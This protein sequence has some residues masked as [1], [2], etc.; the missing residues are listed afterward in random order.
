[1]KRAVS[2][3]VLILTLTVFAVTK[4]PTIG[5]YFYM[6]ADNNLA[7]SANDEL[8]TFPLDKLPENVKI[9]VLLDMPFQSTKLI[10]YTKNSS[11]EIIL[12]NQNTGDPKTLVNFVKKAYENLKTDYNVLVLWSHGSGWY[13]ISYDR[14]KNRAIAYDDSAKDMLTF[15]ELKEAFSKIKKIFG[16]KIDVSIMD[17]CL[18][19]EIEVAVE[20]S[21]YTKYYVASEIEEMDIG[22]DWYNYFTKLFDLLKNGVKRI[23][24]TLAKLMVDVHTSDENYQNNY[25]YN[26]VTMACINSRYVG[27]FLKAFKEYVKSLNLNKTTYLSMRE[28][29]QPIDVNGKGIDLNDLLNTFSN[30]KAMLVKMV[31]KKMVYA[32]VRGIDLSGISIYAPTQI[33]DF[34]NKYTNYFDMKFNK[35]SGWANYIYQLLNK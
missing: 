7:Y 12:D 35:K 23:P 16:K 8:F 17:A 3:I 1:M 14:R 11:K 32:K 31:L 34:K 10:Y 29:L 6:A 28:N 20:L 33:E 5:F 9:A 2:I 22:M 18:M 25:Y 26:P 27:R 13:S 19:G 24:S 4:Q 15:V 21:S 30:D